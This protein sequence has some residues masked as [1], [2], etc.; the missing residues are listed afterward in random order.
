M[1]PTV[2]DNQFPPW[3]SK[4]VLVS[5]RLEVSKLHHPDSLAGRIPVE[6]LQ[7]TGFLHEM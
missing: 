6:I 7:R 4:L 3:L 5:Q 1:L 2:S